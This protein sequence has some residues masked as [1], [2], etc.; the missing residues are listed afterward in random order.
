MGWLIGIHVYC[1]TNTDG[2]MSIVHDVS[3]EWCRWN[4]CKRLL[5]LLA[6]SL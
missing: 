6:L 1:Y 5:T 2:T 4:R 3:S